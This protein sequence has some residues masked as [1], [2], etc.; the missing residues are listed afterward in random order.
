MLRITAEL[1]KRRCQTAEGSE[2]D[3]LCLNLL[4]SPFIM[5]IGSTI[6]EK[7]PRDS[8]YGGACPLKGVSGDSNPPHS[9]AGRLSVDIG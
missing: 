2:E 9:P 7:Y 8:H 3:C 4:M 6:G 1:G 5:G